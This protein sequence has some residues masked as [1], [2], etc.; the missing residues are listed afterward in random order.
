MSD[1]KF[2][3]GFFGAN[4]IISQRTDKERMFLSAISFKGHRAEQSVYS[5]D[6]T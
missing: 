1:T 3:H 4:R 2:G 6:E 5:G